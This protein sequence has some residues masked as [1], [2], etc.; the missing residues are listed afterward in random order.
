M[1][2]GLG[3]SYAYD[4]TWTFRAGLAY[5]ET[6]V[7]DEY[8]TPRIPDQDRKWVSLGASYKYS[9]KITIDAGYAHIFVS[10]PTLQDES[11]TVTPVRSYTLS[12]EYDAGVDVLGVQMRWLF[13]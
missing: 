8:R 7:S 9:D 3:L 6:P 5:E 4:D 13:L 10:S 11:N 12:G 1:R 2:Y